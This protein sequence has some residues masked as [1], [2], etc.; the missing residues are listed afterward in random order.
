MSDIIE[1]QILILYFV[2]VCAVTPYYFRAVVH[3]YKKLVTYEIVRLSAI[4]EVEFNHEI[5]IRREYRNSKFRRAMGISLINLTMITILTGM[6]VILIWSTGIL[7]QFYQPAIITLTIG[8]IMNMSIRISSN[9][10][11]ILM[12]ENS[13]LSSDNMTDI[14]HI[15]GS[16]IM[17]ILYLITAFLSGLAIFS[18]DVLRGVTLTI[19]D[20]LI[21]TT[22]ACLISVLSA[23]MTEYILSIII[24]VEKISLQI[25]ED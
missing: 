22:Y 19:V 8:T 18:Q 14:L 4:E 3:S 6:L 13:N 17:I 20:S 24:P 9:V 12:E 16:V 21:L 2:A 10:P 7:T 25:D 5:D 1:V 23:L 11:T 15:S